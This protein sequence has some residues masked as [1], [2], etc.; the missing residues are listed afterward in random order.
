MPF[1]ISICDVTCG[2]T[3]WRSGGERA[4]K[5]AAIQA[6]N[7]EINGHP[8]IP[9]GASG[10]EVRDLSENTAWGGVTIHRAGWFPPNH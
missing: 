10:F 9:Y 2:R 1:A 8:G 4:T 6:G 7:M 5:E 3:Y